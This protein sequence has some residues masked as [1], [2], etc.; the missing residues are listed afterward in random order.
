MER[1]VHGQMVEY[2]E[3][4]NLL[5]DSQS[6]FRSNQSTGTCIADFSHNVYKGVDESL[7]TGAI[8]LDLTKAFDCVEH[9]IM[10]E[11]LRC[12]GFK[13]CLIH[14]F[15]LYLTDR[16]QMTVVNGETSSTRD[17]TCGVPQGSILGPVLF[18]CYIN[19]LEKHLLH[20]K[21][22]MFADDTALYVQGNTPADIDLKLNTDLEMVSNYL[23]ANKLQLNVGKTKCMMFSA[24]Q[25]FRGYDNRLIFMKV[26]KSNN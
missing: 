5:S 22:S 14:W 23:A 18:I 3:S 8:Y 1:L 6:G 13:T 11:K 20:S 26:H 2:L 9:D 15:K 19:D 21:A 12:L 17:V 7:A 10:L 4:R 24:P 25:K 16:K